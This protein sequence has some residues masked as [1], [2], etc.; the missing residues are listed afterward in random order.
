MLIGAQL[1]RD[2]GTA[3]LLPDQ[4]VILESE[5]NPQAK[6]QQTRRNISEDEQISP[7]SQ[8]KITKD[9]IDD[10]HYNYG[11]TDYFCAGHPDEIY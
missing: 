4:G 9:G 10:I 1:M 8:S 2:V 11:I 5:D 3:I 6:R 7:Y